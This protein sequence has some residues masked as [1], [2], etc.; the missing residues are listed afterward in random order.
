MLFRSE[1]AKINTRETVLW[2]C[3]TPLLVGRLFFQKNSE[4][5]DGH[6]RK[7]MT[8]IAQITSFDEEAAWQTICKTTIPVP[9]SWGPG[10]DPIT[11]KPETKEQRQKKQDAA[12]QSVRDWA[13]KAPKAIAKKTA[14]PAKKSAKASPVAKKTTTAKPAG[15]TTL[16]KFP[17]KTAKKKA[18]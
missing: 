10:I 14:K 17:K 11:L 1:K 9:K 12:V 6:K 16:H 3:V 2:N 15:K 5:Q 7:E 4:L 13:S 18:S 8:R